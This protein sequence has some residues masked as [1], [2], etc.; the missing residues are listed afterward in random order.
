MLRESQ[1]H[2]AKAS[3]ASAEAALEHAE[4]DLERTEFKAPYDGRVRSETVDV[5]QF[6]P[7]ELLW[8]DFTELR[9]WTT[10]MES[11]ILPDRDGREVLEEP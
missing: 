11:K 1:I 10:R 4:Y 7:P 3:P 6:L 8:S 5:G 9:L 2:E